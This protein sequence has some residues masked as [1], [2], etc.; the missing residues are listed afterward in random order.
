M[1]GACVA[2]A[3]PA[4]AQDEQQEQRRPTGGPFSGLFKGSPKEQPHTLDVKGSAFAAWDDNLLAQ[5]PGAGSGE[6]LFDPRFRKSGVARGFQGAI[7][8]GFHRNGTRS[9][10][11]V[12]ANAGLQQYAGGLSTGSAWFHN[13]DGFATLTTKVATR[14]STSASAGVAYAPYFQYAPFL[15]NTTSEESPVGSDM[16]FAVSASTIRATVAS[17]SVDDRL[18]R[19]SRISAGIGWE[20]RVM[21]ENTS[22]NVENR[23]ARATFTHNVTRKLGFHVGYGVIEYRYSFEQDNAPL[24]THNMD[25]GLDYGDG[26]ML[27]FGRHYSLS[28]AISASLAKNGDPVSVLK[29][30]K[31]TAFVVNGSATLSRSIGQSWSASLGYARGTYYAVGFRE[32]MTT[33]SANVGIGGPLATRL[34]F[35]AGGGASRGRFLFSD[36][37]NVIS[38]TASTRLTYALSTNLGLF[39]QASYYDFSLPPGA[40]S[41]GFVPSLAR[42]SVTVGLSTWVPLIKQ[43]RQRRD[44]G[45]QTT[46]GQ[47]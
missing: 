20:Q 39:A 30:G 28:M 32:P 47:P 12:N 21:P 4:A 36:Y 29:T 25:V 42:R 23:L 2:V 45:V 26:L 3:V 18:T 15:R 31:S 40:V 37:G 46:A 17:L 43:R 33:D 13:Y 22:A 27:T 1:A 10:F 9:Q 38:Y 6:N 44:A 34:H 41:L 11:N 7:T 16:G 14:V 35:S 8:Y 5:V 19:R 24:R